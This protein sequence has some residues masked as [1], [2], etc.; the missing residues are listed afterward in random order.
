[1]RAPLRNE[2]GNLGYVCVCVCVCVGHVTIYMGI[3]TVL[4]TL[5]KIPYYLEMTACLP[6]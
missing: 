1:M 6:F 3:L 4:T 2:E 5:L